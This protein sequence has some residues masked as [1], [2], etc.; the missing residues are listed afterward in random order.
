MEA[1]PTV[2]TKK[3]KSNIYNRQTITDC[4]RSYTVLDNV[5]TIGKAHLEENKK[6][7]LLILGGG[8]AKCEAN[9]SG[10]F[11]PEYM[12]LRAVLWENQVNITVVDHSEA[13][14]E[15]CHLI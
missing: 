5:N 11:V 14:L 1:F 9:P 4:L 7:E 8:L 2:E 10:S 3:D 13:V 15:V 12:E 6:V